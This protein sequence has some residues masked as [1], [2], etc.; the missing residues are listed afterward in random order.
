MNTVSTISKV[1][2]LTILLSIFGTVIA[3]L[4]AF[5][6]TSRPS[7]T[8]FPLLFLNEFLMMA[9]ILDRKFVPPIMCA[10]ALSLVG[11]AMT[12]PSEQMAAISRL[13]L[14]TAST[15]ILAIADMYASRL[16]EGW[17]TVL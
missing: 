13:G 6:F 3:G 16:K 11:Y 2:P 10:I 8:F 9:F 5:F 17:N 1:G 7:D 12:F 14:C 15:I 4:A